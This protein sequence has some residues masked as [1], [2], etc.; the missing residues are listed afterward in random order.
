MSD[1]PTRASADDSLKAT[2][3]FAVLNDHGV[4]YVLVGG[5]AAQMRGAS[6]PTTDADITPETSVANL[7]HLA[8]ALRALK[9]RI[10][11]DRVPEGL[12]FD[13]SAAALAGMKTLNLQTVYGDLDLT[14][15]PD[16][17]N[18]YGDLIRSATA[19]PV[20]A[21]VVQ[22]AALNDIIRSKTAAGRQKD[23]DAL[24]ELHALAHRAQPKR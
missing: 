16:G 1:G 3:I 5:Y 8:T 4:D 14:F 18:G 17:T 12:P 2:S 6:R 10:R 11:T 13:P 24:P 20:G 19:E 23:L 9:A 21:T 22:V 7:A 15:T